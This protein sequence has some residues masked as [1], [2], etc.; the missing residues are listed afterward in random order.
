[1]VGNSPAAFLYKL[2]KVNQKN[3]WCTFAM[4]HDMIPLPSIWPSLVTCFSVR[5]F[6][7]SIV[8]YLYIMFHSLH[9]NTPTTSYSNVCYMLILRNANATIYT[10]SIQVGGFSPFEKYESKWES[11]LNRGEHTKIFETTTYCSIVS[12]W[13]STMLGNL[14]P[15][16][17]ATLPVSISK[18]R[19][20][21]PSG[22]AG[23]WFRAPKNP[24]PWQFRYYLSIYLS[25]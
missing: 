9:A 21:G 6:F 16:Y 20:F 22:R 24:T 14:N 12:I 15:S 7:R 8:L 19:C 23:S 11:S 10:T 4:L 1:M 13:K 25:F 18:P 2:E 5:R 3:G 17:Q